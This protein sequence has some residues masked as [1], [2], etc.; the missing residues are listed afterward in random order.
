M[1]K[2][3]LNTSLI[4]LVTACSTPKEEPKVAA[5]AATPLISGIDSQYRD[6]NVRIQDDANLHVNGG[7]LA[8]TEI[9]ADKAVWGAFSELR[10]STLPQLHG[11]IQ[12]AST[13]LAY[14]ED[15][16]AKKI[17]DLFSSYMNEQKL[18][19]LGISPLKAEFAQIDA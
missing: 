10:E 3:I 19:E 15:V 5:P 7:W 17:A 13:T 12:K 2:Y 8:K 1:K 16:E 18:E 14:N 9:P 6:A 11:I 4:L